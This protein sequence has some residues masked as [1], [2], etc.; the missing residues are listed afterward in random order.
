MKLIRSLI[1]VLC[2]AALV[3]SSAAAVNSEPAALAVLAS[4]ESSLQA[5]ARACQELGDV[6]GP[7]SIPALAALLNQEHLADYARSGLEGIKDPAAGAALRKALPMLEGRYL[8]GVVNSLGGRREVA[9]VGELQ[10]LAL[11]AKRG[12]AAE[13]LASLGMIGN[14]AAAKT[15]QKVLADGPADLRVP[16]AH[17]ALIAAGHLAKDGQKGPARDLLKAVVSGLPTGHLA[18]TA[19]RL[20]DSLDAK[21]ASARK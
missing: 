11:D 21:P 6:G 16:A 13:A 15:L 9:A 10:K 3:S 4:A 17:A 2:A 5:K 8:S 20:T 1:P 19:Q 18:T 14:G 7:K 12:V